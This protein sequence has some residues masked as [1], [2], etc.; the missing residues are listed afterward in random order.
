MMNSALDVVEIRE[1]LRE[2]KAVDVA[3]D[4][5][6][7]GA[8]LCRG[9]VHALRA[10]PRHE[11]LREDRVQHAEAGRRADVH[12]DRVGREPRHDLAH[13]RADLGERLIPGD[14]LVSIARPSSAGSGGD[15]VNRAACAASAPSRSRSRASRRARRRGGSRARGPASSVTSR[16]QSASQMRQK[17]WRTSPSLRSPSRTSLRHLPV[18]RRPSRALGSLL[19]ADGWRIGDSSWFFGTSEQ[20]PRRFAG[21]EVRRPPPRPG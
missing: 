14:A 4:G 3:R 16:P 11:A 8:V 1:R 18:S 15:P 7:V 21:Y 17:V 10:E 13:L 20:S 6:L 19:R 2:R 9:R 5:E 12:R